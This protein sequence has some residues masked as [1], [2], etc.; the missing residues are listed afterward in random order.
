MN[1]TR[2]FLDR[3]FVL[4]ETILLEKRFFHHELNVL[5]KKSGDFFIVFDGKGNSAMAEILSTKKNFEICINKLFPPSPRLGIDFDLGQSI[6]KSD[7][8]NIALQKATELGVKTFSPL[9]TE[10]VAMNRKSLDSK[11]RIEK[12]YQIARGA[13][14]QCGE[15]WVPF[16]N[17]PT[18]LIEWAKET[19][20]Q[21]KILLYPNAEQKLSDIVFKETVSIAIGPEGDF[22]TGEVEAL[23]EFDFIPVT[24]GHRILRAETA[25]ISA[26]S[27]IRYG[28]KEF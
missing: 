25:A 21:T 20:S 28:A 9:L 11:K 7:P 22:T 1:L 5:R 12:W 14:E 8:F 27:A 2:T 18:N 15:N 16:I 17:E 13:C 6:I 19:S 10:R 26:I 3:S 23:K 4:N 24:M